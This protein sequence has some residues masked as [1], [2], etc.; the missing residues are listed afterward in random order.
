MY[1]VDSFAFAVAGLVVFLL[2]CVAWG[3]VYVRKR[4]E[5]R[6]EEARH[7]AHTRELLDKAVALRTRMSLTLIRDK[8]PA[9]EFSSVGVAVTDEAI[10]LACDC[11][12]LP[13]DIPDLT[14]TVFGRLSREGKQSFTSFSS[15][16]LRVRTNRNMALVDLALPDELST[17]QRRVFLRMDNR[18][19][20][21]QG[22]HVWRAPEVVPGTNAQPQWEGINSDMVHLKDISA[23]G[24]ALIFGQGET[25]Y[26][27]DSILTSFSF[28]P[29]KSGQPQTLAIMGRCVRLA[30]GLSEGRFVAG[31]LFIGVLR[32][33]ENNP[34][35]KWHHVQ[36]KEGVKE[37]NPWVL[38]HDF[39]IRQRLR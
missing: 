30:L 24:V 28:T 37:L 23:G 4:R 35:G 19:G 2:L 17:S 11:R 7:R 39:Q 14:A 33:D 12:G 9:G 6:E 38:Y 32:P 26:V 16:I 31:V 13:N 15:S 10:T 3:V 29:P 21:I 34:K 5:I 1:Y 18:E 20:L 22:L 36:P 25:V 8:K 27:G